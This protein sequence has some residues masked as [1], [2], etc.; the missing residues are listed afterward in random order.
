MSRSKTYKD[1]LKVVQTDLLILQSIFNK[2]KKQCQILKF[3]QDSKVKEIN[4]DSYISRRVK[5]L[6]NEKLV[7][8]KDKLYYVPVKRLVKIIAQESNMFDEKQIDKVIEVV[9][10][11]KHE[12]DDIDITTNLLF[13]PSILRKVPILLFG[14]FLLVI[15]NVT[16]KIDLFKENIG[17]YLFTIYIHSLSLN[18]IIESMREQNLRQYPDL[19]QEDRDDLLITRFET[20]ADLLRLRK[21]NIS[22]SENAILRKQEIW[23]ETEKILSEMERKI[24]G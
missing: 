22:V 23:E 20:M 3:I 24:P 7:R 8:E 10:Q 14:M 16:T 11:Y 13:D 15:L 21:Q 4:S 1:D 18:P 9:R 12:V 19:S 6:M 17:L 5:F 2:Q